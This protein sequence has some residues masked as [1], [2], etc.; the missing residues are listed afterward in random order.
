MGILRPGIAHV[1]F[2]CSQGHG[3]IV[4]MSY[5]PATGTFRPLELDA[6]CCPICKQ[7]DVDPHG[8][9]GEFEQ[10]GKIRITGMGSA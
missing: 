4:A 6:E 2:C 3:W 8:T 5:S 10:E 1:Q 9:K 7:P